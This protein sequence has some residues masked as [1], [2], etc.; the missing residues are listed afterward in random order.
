MTG[1]QEIS[2]HAGEVLGKGL[3]FGIFSS[4]ELL[5]NADIYTP[6]LREFHVIFWF[7]RGHGTY[8]IDFQEYPVK[9]NTLVLVPRDQ[10]NYFAPLD[11]KSTEI[12]AL[13]FTPEFLYRNDDDIRHLFH[14]TVADHLEGIQILE[15]RK[16]EADYLEMLSRNMAM[17][18]EHWEGKTREHAFY[19]WLSLFLIFSNQLQSSTREQ[20]HMDENARN[21]IRFNEELEEHFRKEFKVEFYLEKLGIA[22]KALSR[23]TQEHYKLSPKS[24]IDQRRM[25]ELRRLLKATSLPIKEIAYKMGFDEPTNMVKYFRKHSGTTPTAFRECSKYE[26]AG[27]FLP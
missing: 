3:P 8:Y 24:V 5:S 26:A 2:K 25:L 12:Q 11:K 18:Y 17:V 1:I 19:H 13:A 7:K 9:P 22:V 4:E 20:C 16:D 21:L 15:L 27:Q 14:F 10:V 23:L 6:S